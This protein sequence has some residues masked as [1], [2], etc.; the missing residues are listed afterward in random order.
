MD[1]EYKPLRPSILAAP[2]QSTMY[3]MSSQGFAAFNMGSSMLTGPQNYMYGNHQPQQQPIKRTKRKKV[4][5]ACVYCRRSHM[6]CDNNRPCSRC[7]KRNISHLCHDEAKPVRGKRQQSQSDDEEEVQ[8]QQQQQQQQQGQGQ[9]GQG[10][11]SG[12][13]TPNAGMSAQFMNAGGIQNGLF[14]SEH[15]GSEF[16]SLNDFLTMFDDVV[17]EG[18]PSQGQNQGQQQGQGQSQGQSENGT[19]T[20][21]RQGQGMHQTQSQNHAQTQSQTQTQAQAMSQGQRQQPGHQHQQLQSPGMA[22]PAVT[23]QQQQ[24]QSQA[25]AQSQNLSNASLTHEDPPQVSEAARNKFFLTAADPTIDNSPEER[26]KQ[27]IYAKLEAGLLQPFNYVKG[28]A[29]LQQYMDNYMNISSKQ[30]ILKPL[31]IFR[32]AFRA[33]A[34]SLKDIDLV[35]VEE[36]FERMLLDYD[37]VF[38]TMAIPACLWRRTGEIYRGNKEF[39]GLVGVPVEDLRNGKLAIYELMSEDSAVNYWEKY[40]NI[41][42]DSGQKAVLT[43]CNLRSKD[44]RKRKLCCFSFTIRRDRYNI[45]SCIVGNFIPINP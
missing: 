12:L 17:Y 15:A 41:A 8:G 29:R 22:H 39:A 38:T 23:Q 16:S 9:Q 31:S 44:G 2:G 5:Q 42:F 20:Q 18:Q 34:Q 45:P 1:N 35:L 28:Y 37:R 36:A 33:I 11:V 32:P 3:D 26:L 13:N 6:T 21:Y 40:G 14:F 19:G 30:R 7:V 27:V 24:G 4:D 10:Q 25:Q 43:S